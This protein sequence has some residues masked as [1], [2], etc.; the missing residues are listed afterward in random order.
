MDILPISSPLLIEEAAR[1][2]REMIVGGALAPGARL[3]ERKLGE[4][5]GISRTP[6]REALRLLA[7]EHLVEIEPRRGARVA[8][9]DRAVIEHVFDVMEALEALA[10]ETACDRLTD[11]QITELRAVHERMVRCFERGDR[12]RFFALNRQFHEAILTGATNP[13]LERIYRSL[14]SQMQRARYMLLNT[15]EEWRAAVDE[16]AEIVER[17]GRRDR[18]GVGA[19]VRGHLR[20][21]RAKVLRELGR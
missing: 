7:A 17:L 10:V 15:T 16:H 8:P 2:L 18:A 12:K 4:A 19:A 11:A 13:V 1:R 6:L 20:S 9:L 5:L 3:S 14:D 21:K